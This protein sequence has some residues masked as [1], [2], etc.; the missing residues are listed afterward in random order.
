MACVIY[1]S[2]LFFSFFLNSVLKAPW[3]SGRQAQTSNLIQPAIQPIRMIQ[4]RLLHLV[5][6][7][8]PSIHPS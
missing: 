1:Y 8:L 6:S 7:S 4:E 3:I 2:V 5:L